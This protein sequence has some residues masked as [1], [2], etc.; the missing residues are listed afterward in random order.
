[1]I[2]ISACLIGLNCKYDGTNSGKECFIEKVQRGNVIP[3]CPEQLG[4]LPTPRAPAEIVG[5]TGEDVLDGSAKV[6][7]SNGMDVTSAFV[8]GAQEMLYLARLFDFMLVA[9]KHDNQQVI[10]TLKVE[11]IIFKQNSPSC[12]CGYIYDG[13]FTGV[14]R[15][16]NGVTTALLLR[17]GF[18]VIAV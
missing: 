15:Q 10:E 14:L 1:M 16:G 2:I 5:G 6:Q 12:G 9:A 11:K 18:N 4:G 7:T 3:I 8:R 17:E 13:T